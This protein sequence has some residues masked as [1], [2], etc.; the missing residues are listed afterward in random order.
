MKKF[1]LLIYLAVTV[2]ANNKEYE[3][4]LYEKVLGSI[5][6]EEIINI[7]SDEQLKDILL[8]SKK[9]LIVDSCKK[10]TVLIGNDFKT[11]CDN[12]PCFA[13]SYKMFKKEENVIGAFYWRK[14]RPQLKLKTNVLNKF[15]LNLPENL[16]KYSK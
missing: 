5:F 8:K 11:K 4:K 14:G 7:Y 1:I 3:L 9:F 12:L 6:E 13:T 10:A 16:K 15:A 2:F